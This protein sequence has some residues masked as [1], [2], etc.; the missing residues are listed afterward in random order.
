MKYIFLRSK[1][2]PLKLTLTHTFVTEGTGPYNL[3]GNMTGFE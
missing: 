1:V 2:V 3:H